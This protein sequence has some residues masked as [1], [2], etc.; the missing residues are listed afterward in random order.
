MSPGSIVMP[1][2]LLPALEVLGPVEVVVAEPHALEIDHARRADQPLERQVADELAAGVEVRGRVEVR[3]DME[4]RR[5]LL[6][7]RPVEREPLDPFDRRAV[8]AGE[9]R[10]VDGEVLGE[11]EHVHG[12]R[13]LVCCGDERSASAGADRVGRGRS[14]G[15]GA[16]AAVRR[17]AVAR[18]SSSAWSGAGPMPCA[19]S[20]SSVAESEVVACACRAARRRRASADRVVDPAEQATAAAAPRE[21]VALRRQAGAAAD[22]AARPAV[23]GERRQSRRLDAPLARGPRR[24]ASRPGERRREDR[25]PARPRPVV[26][27]PRARRV[28]AL[29][30][31]HDRRPSATA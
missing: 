22:Q 18:R 30:P 1:G 14:S 3:A 9:R 23:A 17:S 20:S 16:E 21:V 8:V 19:A 7:A 11:V 10:R 15:R 4:R 25:L 6:P 27:A 26:R 2:V 28:P 5:D 29:R 13:S 12:S 31:R 24:G